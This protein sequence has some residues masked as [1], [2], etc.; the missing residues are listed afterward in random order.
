MVT[1][2]K[3]TFKTI[4]VFVLSVGYLLILTGAAKLIGGFKPDALLQTVEPLLAIELRHILR[5]AGIVELFIGILAL[6]YSK[7]ELALKSILWLSSVLISYRIFLF[8]VGYD[9]PCACLGNLRGLIPLEP[10]TVDIV[11][12][13]LLSYMFFGSGVSLFFLRRC[14]DPLDR[15]LISQQYPTVATCDK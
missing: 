8:G 11:M 4:R 2:R 5:L 1:T 12:K 3:R 14:G 10:S 9:F 15:T 6:F 13:I 7:Q